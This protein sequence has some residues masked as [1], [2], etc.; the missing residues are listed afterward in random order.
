MRRQLSVRPSTKRPDAYGG[1]KIDL[2]D[3]VDLRRA[4]KRRPRT[5][6]AVTNGRTRAIPKSKRKTIVARNGAT[7]QP[8][9]KGERRGGRP[10]GSR[11]KTTRL[12]KEATIMA[13]ELEG[14][15]GKGKDGLVGY[16]RMLA[17]KYPAVFAQLLGRILPL[18]IVGD[19]TRPVTVIHDTMK[20]RDAAQAYADTVQSPLIEHM[21]LVEDVP[22]GEAEVVDD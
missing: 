11:N 8:I 22:V 19:A 9:Q 4:A 14:N 6:V 2:D 7:L 5:R 12:L 20:L 15:N 18:Q 21:R 3:P 16:M 13:A 1:R 10:V 17:K